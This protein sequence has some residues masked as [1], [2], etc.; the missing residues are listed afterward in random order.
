MERSLA[1][2]KRAPS[3]ERAAKMS[4]SSLALSDLRAAAI[5][6]VLAFHSCLAYLG[7]L[8]LYAQ[9]FDRP[10]YQWRA[11]P[12]IDDQRWFGF[13]L[14]SAA[15]DVYLMSLMFFLS[16]IFVWPSLARQGSWDSS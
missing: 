15:Q 8:P 6:V 5:L 2:A 1:F 10:P 7:S 11:F 13:D 9:P 4:R 3:A 16:G 12:I 14:F